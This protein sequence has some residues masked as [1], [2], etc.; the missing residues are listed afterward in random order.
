MSDVTAGTRSEASLGNNS[1]CRCE[2]CKH[3]VFELHVE[4][5]NIL[6]LKHRTHD[7]TKGTHSTDWSC[8]FEAEYQVPELKERSN[9]S[10]VASARSGRAQNVSFRKHGYFVSYDIDSLSLLGRY[11]ALEI[12]QEGVPS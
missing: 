7:A 4:Y 11:R 9:T 2:S 10:R 5:P 8:I 12:D 6:P 3:T 1:Q